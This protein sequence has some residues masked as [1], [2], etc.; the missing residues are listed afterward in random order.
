MSQAKADVDAE[1]AVKPLPPPTAL[2][3]AALASALAAPKAAPGPKAAPKP[4][5]GPVSSRNS[6][7]SYR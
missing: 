4:V 5:A 7:E 2:E 6:V 3:A 1:M